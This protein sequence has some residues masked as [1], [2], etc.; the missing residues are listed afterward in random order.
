MIA[1]KI[2]TSVDSGG[3]SVNLLEAITDYQKDNTTVDIADKYVITFKGTRRLRMTT[4]GWK[5]KVL[6]RDGTDS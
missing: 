1:E 2:L 5:L 6:W 3:F 4:Q